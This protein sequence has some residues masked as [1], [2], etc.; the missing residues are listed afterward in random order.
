MKVQDPNLAAGSINTTPSAAP[1]SAAARGNA[2]ERA[3]GTDR[4]ELSGF[5]GRLGSALRTQSQTR[6]QRV[7]A[8]EREFQSGNFT[9]DAGQTSRALVQETLNASAVEKGAPG[10]T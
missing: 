3:G 5:A 1:S 8:L 4:V 2:A 6:A 7:A 9:R 10:R